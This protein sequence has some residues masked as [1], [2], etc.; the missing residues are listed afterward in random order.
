MQ[1]FGTELTLASLLFYVIS[2]LV[3]GFLIGS[4]IGSFFEKRENEKK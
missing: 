2:L 3:E 4:L 1:S